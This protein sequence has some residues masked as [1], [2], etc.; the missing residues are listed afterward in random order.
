VTVLEVDCKSKSFRNICERRRNDDEIFCSFWEILVT[1]FIYIDFG[2]VQLYHEPSR[3]F[4]DGTD[5]CLAIL[6]A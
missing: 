6:I 3:W 1:A 4:I 2:L 5:L